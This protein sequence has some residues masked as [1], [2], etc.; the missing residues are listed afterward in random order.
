[1]RAIQEGDALAFEG[2]VREN[3]RRFFRIALGFLGEAEEARDAAQETF[4]RVWRNRESW[5]RGSDPSVWARR[6]LANHC[7]DRLRRRRVRSGPSLEEWEEIRGGPAPDREAP[8]PLGRA[9]SRE[10]GRRALE[11]VRRLPERMRVTVLMRFGQELT[12]QEVADA[13][14]C[15]LGTVKATLHRALRRLR[16]MLAGEEGS[17]VAE[18]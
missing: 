5:K 18:G 17:R 11:A 8:D 10:E 14:G 1:M 13:M 3:E 9:Q 12:L 16:A 2:F 7:I 15:S 6:I 4:V